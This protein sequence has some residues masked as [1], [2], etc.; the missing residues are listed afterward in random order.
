M[1]QLKGS[2]HVQTMSDEVGE[3]R[4]ESMGTILKLGN[5]Y[6]NYP[7][8]MVVFACCKVTEDHLHAV[9]RTPWYICS[10]APL[11]IIHN[12]FPI[13]TQIWCGVAVMGD[14]DVGAIL[15]ADTT[16][17]RDGAEARIDSAAKIAIFVRRLFE[18]KL[19]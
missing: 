13:A 6:T 12:D 15:F 11:T 5:R 10:E 16:E 19:H 3:A 17:H 8:F 1:R 9:L 14:R 2:D 4:P 7:W 18:G